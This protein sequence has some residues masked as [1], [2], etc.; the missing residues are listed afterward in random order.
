MIE[1]SPDEKAQAPCVFPPGQS[2]TS[3]LRTAR[4][5]SH[6]ALAWSRKS[7]NALTPRRVESVLCIPM[8]AKITGQVSDQHTEKIRRWHEQAAAK[9]WSLKRLCRHRSAITTAATEIPAVNSCQACGPGAPFEFAR[10]CHSLVCT[11]NPDHSSWHGSARLH[12]AQLVMG[13]LRASRG[14]TIAVATSGS[15][16]PMVSCALIPVICLA[17]DHRISW[18]FVLPHHE[19]V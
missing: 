18:W 12:N 10:G 4:L 3:W 16:F 17:G 14:R 13:N 11:P 6:A 19:L 15:A 1:V 5:V 9:G 7:S 8:E 2:K